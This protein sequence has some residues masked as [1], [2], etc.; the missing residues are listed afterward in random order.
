M[1]SCQAAGFGWQG[2]SRCISPA[3]WLFLTRDDPTPC[4][5]SHG[6][7]TSL[8]DHQSLCSDSLNWPSFLP[9]SENP[10]RNSNWEAEP[11]A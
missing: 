4:F 6:N 5:T 11:G 10:G 2:G 7:S 3:M 9:K 8:A 1:D